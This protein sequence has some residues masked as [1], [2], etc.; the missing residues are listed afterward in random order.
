MINIE[1]L[2]PK[3]QGTRFMRSALLR[4]T[5]YTHIYSPEMARLLV[6]LA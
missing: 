1:L 3:A 6:E 2:K 4:R 5:S